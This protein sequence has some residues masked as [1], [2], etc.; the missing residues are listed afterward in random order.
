MGNDL[1]QVLSFNRLP[2]I[3]CVN[4]TSYHVCVYVSFFLC[5]T[6]RHYV[7]NRNEGYKIPWTYIIFHLR[8]MMMMNP[9]SCRKNGITDIYSIWIYKLFTR[10]QLMIRNYHMRLILSDHQDHFT[11]KGYEINAFF[12]KYIELKAQQMMYHCIY[13]HIP[14]LS[15]SPERV[16]A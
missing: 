16:V 10:L 1:R 13:I 12:W 5:S 7:M 4:M 11:I 15:F 8:M 9:W 14:K 6:S 3:L 2:I